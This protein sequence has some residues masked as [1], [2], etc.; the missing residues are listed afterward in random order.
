MSRYAQTKSSLWQ[1]TVFRSLSQLGQRVYIYLTS[2]PSSNCV[3][4][5]VLLPHYACGDLSC[6]GFDCSS[7]DFLNGLKEVCE[8]GLA[9]WDGVNN[10]VL[11]TRHLV[12]NPITSDDHFKSAVKR[13]QNLPDTPLLQELARIVE[14]IP[15]HKLN[16]PKGYTLKNT[17]GLLEYLP[18]CKREDCEQNCG[19]ACEQDCEQPPVTATAS[20]KDND[21]GLDSDSEGLEVHPV[22]GEL[23][24]PVTKEIFF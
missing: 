23:Y 8:A 18:S 11:I 22:T 2:S 19:Q 13:I 20:S 7:D 16:S 17:K 24:D 15:A 3:G 14:S 4:I 10:V 6:S 1:D 12:E 9:V 5:Y 21:P